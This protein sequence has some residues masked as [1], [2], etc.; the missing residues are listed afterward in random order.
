MAPRRLG[1][2]IHDKMFGPGNI[3][4]GKKASLNDKLH[5]VG[6]AFNGKRKED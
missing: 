6:N 2:L 3:F 4:N 5:G 1:N